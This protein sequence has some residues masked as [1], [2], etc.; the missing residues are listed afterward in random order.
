MQ[1]RDS[2]VGLESST[3]S[4]ISAAQQSSLARRSRAYQQA[5]RYGAS[6]LAGESYE[7]PSRLFH[8]SFGSRWPST[9]TLNQST[10]LYCATALPNEHIL[11]PSGLFCRRPTSWNFL[12][13]CLRV[14]T[15]SFER[16]RRQLKTELFASY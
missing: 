6:L 15:L 4:V 1:Q 7:I 8:T 14:P 12:P 2:F 16:F 9:T 11:A 3:G 13:D 5:E 10:P